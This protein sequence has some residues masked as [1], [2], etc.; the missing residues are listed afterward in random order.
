MMLFRLCAA[1]MMWL[2][3]THT[4]MTFVFSKQIHTCLLVLT[5]MHWLEGR[6][7][8]SKGDNLVSETKSPA[9]WM[10]ADNPTE[11]STIKLKTRA[12]YAG[13]M[14]SEHLGHSTP[15]I[16]WLYP[17]LWRYTYLLVLTLMLWQRGSDMESK[18]G[19]F[20]SSP[21]LNAG[22]EPRVSGTKCLSDCMSADKPTEL[23]RIRLTIRTQ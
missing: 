2:T 12:Q 15:L 22:S 18:G 14:I 1:W 7:T 11:L 17:W 16:I 4:E 23:S 9:D 8:E 21:L 20:S 13:P 6:H 3:H 19:E 5:V 10:S